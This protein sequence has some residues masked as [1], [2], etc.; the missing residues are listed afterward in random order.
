[1][2]STKLLHYRSGENWPRNTA[3]LHIL[4]IITYFNIENVST[5]IEITFKALNSNNETL[6]NYVILRQIC[7][8]EASAGDENRARARGR[9]AGGRRPNGNE[10]TAAK[11]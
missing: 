7:E 1:M 4:T 5:T 2:R 8:S 3:K 10:P 11:R 6:K 9:R